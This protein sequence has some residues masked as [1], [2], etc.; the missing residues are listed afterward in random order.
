MLDRR[1][2]LA[3]LLDAGKLALASSVGGPLLATEG[4]R[5]DRLVPFLG[6]GRAPLGRVIG[7]GLGGRQAVDL[8]ELT[9]GTE[10]IANER[11]YIRTRAPAAIEPAAGWSVRIHGQVKAATRVGIE[12][13]RAG[14]RPQGIHLLECSGNSADRHFG[15]ISTARWAGVPV[16]DLLERVVKTRRGRL[17]LISGLDQ[18]PTASHASVA[19]ASWIFR[20]EE[21][22]RAFLATTMNGEPLPLDHGAPVRL[23]VPGW[24]GCTAIKWVNEVAWVGGDAEATSQMREFA[25]RTHQAGL[26]RIAREY[27]PATV[28]SAAMP[29]RVERWQDGDQTRYRLLGILWGGERTVNRL[30]IRFGG[31]AWEAVEGLE[32]RAL[33]GWTFWTHTLRPERHGRLRIELRVADPDMPTRRLDR[34]YYARTIEVG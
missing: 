2:F 8:T 29:V 21:L 5:F 33:N 1:P 34:G 23:I 25:Q 18:H 11:F 3:R 12:A 6:E 22:E 26:P 16:R 14:E 13:L 15:L 31:G 9:P 27:R 19:G 32:H 20:P 10:T 24:Y 28:E 7:R 17:V 4:A 30:I